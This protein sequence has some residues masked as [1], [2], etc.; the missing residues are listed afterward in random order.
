M[1]KAQVQLL[2]TGKMIF[3]GIGIRDIRRFD[4]FISVTI[5]ECSIPPPRASVQE[6]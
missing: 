5:Q 3:V 4:L 6:A 1:A 2:G